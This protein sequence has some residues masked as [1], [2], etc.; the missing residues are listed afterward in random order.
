VVKWDWKNATQLAVPID[1]LATPSLHL[2]EF[3]IDKVE[4]TSDGRL[5]VEARG[6]LVALSADL[7]FENLRLVPQAACVYAADIGDDRAVTLQGAG[8]ARV[9]FWKF[10]KGSSGTYRVEPDGQIAGRFSRCQISPDERYLLA[11]GEAGNVMTIYDLAQK[12]QTQWEPV[13]KVDLQADVVTAVCW[14]SDSQQIATGLE[15]GKAVIWDFA[16]EVAGKQLLKNEELAL[17][18]AEKSDPVRSIAMDQTASTVLIVR[19]G[20]ASVHRKAADQWNAIELAQSGETVA[21]DISPDGKRAVTATK[22]GTLTLWNTDE[23]DNS[24]RPG[25]VDLPQREAKER[26][27]LDLYQ[28]KSEVRFVQFSADGKSLISAEAGAAGALIWPTRWD[29]TTK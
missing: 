12:D 2:P 22:V 5:L 19:S 28:H 23:I 13:V 4:Q 14:S 3:A 8:E 24:S 10:A 11:I 21:G 6:H 7:Q 16:G 1:V 27:L 15:T 20:G 25:G 9:R 18:D 29:A 26:A 17:A